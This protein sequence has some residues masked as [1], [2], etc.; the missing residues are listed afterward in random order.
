MRE[1]ERG[2]QAILL[3]VSL[4][5]KQSQSY[6]KKAEASL[7][8]PQAAPHGLVHGHYINTNPRAKRKQRSD[9]TH[10]DCSLRGKRHMPTVFYHND[11]QQDDE[12]S[13][14]LL[15]HTTPLWPLFPRLPQLHMTLLVVVSPG[16]SNRP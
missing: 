8:S 10:A 15:I 1:P 6:Q 4:A 5:E 7:E 9:V 14:V 3:V 13:T 16:T 11:H 2:R 12:I